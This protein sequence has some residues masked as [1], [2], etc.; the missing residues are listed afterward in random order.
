M[1]TLTPDTKTCMSHL[2]LKDTFDSLAFIEGEITTYNRF[3]VDGRIHQEFYDAEEAPDRDYSL[4]GSL[5]S[6]C[7]SIIKG[8][9]TPLSFKFILSL[10]KENFP[11]FLSKK[12]LSYRPDEIQG[13]YMNLRYDGT[14]LSCV[15][16]TSMSTFTMDKSLDEAWDGWVRTFFAEAQIEFELG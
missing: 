1:I 16:G 10:D 5:R 13:L 14:H 2:L 6:Y 7:L 9:R 11:D 4:W 3:T 12:E 8:K 15:T